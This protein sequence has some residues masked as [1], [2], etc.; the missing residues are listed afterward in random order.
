MTFKSTPP[1]NV[2]QTPWFALAPWQLLDEPGLQAIAEYLNQLATQQL[3]AELENERTYPRVVRQQLHA[4]GLSDFFIDPVVEAAT[5]DAQTTALLAT[6]PHLVALISLCTASNGSLGITVGVNMLA[7]LPIYIAG[8]AEQLAWMAE[9]LRRGDYAAL[10]LTELAHGSDLLAN[11]TLAEA[12]Y[13]D[14]TGAFVLCAE[15]DI[16]TSAM[17]ASHYRL[18]GRKDTINGGS[19]RELMVVFAR[20]RAKRAEHG[21]VN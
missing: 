13:F 17:P 10:F 20:S 1:I 9:R 8:S 19:Q 12:G 5:P 2:T 4:L 6:F 7:L 21:S 11:E 16:T 3:L 14:H 15:G 18:H